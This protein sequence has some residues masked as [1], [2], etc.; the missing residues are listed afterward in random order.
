MG[1]AGVLATRASILSGVHAFRHGI[2]DGLPDNAVGID[3]AA[4]ELLA[5]TFS[6]AGYATGAFGKWHV[7]TQDERGRTPNPR[8]PPSIRW[9]PHP[10][11]AG[12][13]EFFG[14]LDSELGD[15]DAW[16]ALVYRYPPA[17]GAPPT[18]HE[19]TL[20]AVTEHAT[21]ATK[22]AALDW[23]GGQ[24]GP[25][26]ALVAF[27]APH[28][29]NERDWGYGDADPAC[30]RSPELA[31]LATETCADPARA[32]YQGLAEC[33]DLHVEALLA[34]LDADVLDDTLV[35]F[36]GDNGT[37]SVVQEGDWIGAGGKGTAHENGLRVPLVVADGATLRTGAAGRI[38]FPGR[39]VAAPVHVLDLWRIQLRREPIEV[40]VAV[41]SAVEATSPLV[42]ERGHHLS[43]DVPSEGLR[44]DGDAV[45]LAQVFGN[46]LHNA[47]KYTPMGGA[48]GVRARLDADEIVVEV[49]DSG[50]GIAPDVLRHLFDPF[51]QAPQGLERSTGASASGSPSRRASSSSTQAGS[52]WRP[53]STGAARSR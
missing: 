17:P 21:P 7:G 47:A 33:M 40:S 5:E 22:D 18:T 24:A 12:F 27:H 13:T 35:V 42:E 46:L 39:T 53:R 19:V 9:L 28:A 4:F 52:W 26:F 41:A 10:G 25:W 31:C 44:V 30:V 34:G 32:V 11:L 3:P 15:Y 37:P 36:V 2:G 51:V 20:T 29:P 1:R 38:A 45:R 16:T 49:H 23:I 43:I 8:R 48:I 6:A 50:V 14:T